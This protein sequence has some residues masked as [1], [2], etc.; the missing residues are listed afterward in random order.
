MSGKLTLE[1]AKA[2]LEDQM[3]LMT[4]AER[5]AF[6]ETVGA[7]DTFGKFLTATGTPASSARAEILRACRHEHPARCRCR[8]GQVWLHPNA[9]A[10]RRRH[11]RLAC[12]HARGGQ[13][14]I[15]GAYNSSSVFL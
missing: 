6:K 3:A 11:L 8:R 7:C 4:P 1:R 14:E 10:R 2:I 13:R 9:A 5:A 15:L 12:E